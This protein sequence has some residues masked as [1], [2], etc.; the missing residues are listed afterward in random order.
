[1][2][3][4]GEPVCV[5]GASERHSLLLYYLVLLYNLFHFR[6]PVP[7]V[8]SCIALK[9]KQIQKC[10]STNRNDIY[11]Y[12]YTLYIIPPVACSCKKLTDFQFTVYT[13]I[14]YIYIYIA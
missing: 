2:K 6:L 5:R 3:F 12:I 10:K 11:I 13:I 14:A 9:K 1:M 4:Y 8:I 7:G